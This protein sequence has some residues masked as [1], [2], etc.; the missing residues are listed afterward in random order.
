MCFSPQRT[1]AADES[2]D[3]PTPLLKS[4][5]PGASPEASCTRPTLGNCCS[6]LPDRARVVGGDENI[7][8]GLAHSLARLRMEGIVAK[9]IALLLIQLG[10]LPNQHVHAVVDVDLLEVLRVRLDPH[11]EAAEGGDHR[12]L[13]DAPRVLDR[14][15]T[16]LNSSYSSVSRMPSSA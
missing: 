16:R 14:K 12:R 7:S 4:D 11:E 6:L 15:S 8:I 10:D 2:P 9:F 13:L 5:D 3:K 1:R